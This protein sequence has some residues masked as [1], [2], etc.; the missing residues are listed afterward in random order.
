[1]IYKLEDCPVSLDEFKKHRR[2]FH[3]ELDDVLEANLLAA[4]NHIE[5]FTGIDFS[6]D[7]KET[8]DPVPPALKH[9]IIL[10][11]ATLFEN[12]TDSVSE[13]NTQS[14]NLIK[15]FRRWDRI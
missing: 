15:A 1:M 10:K 2:I 6:T 4:T 12:P 5:N 7:Y 8:D 9:A 11:A 3:S 14:D 13:R